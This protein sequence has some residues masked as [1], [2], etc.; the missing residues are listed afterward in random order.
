MR[1]KDL[2]LIKKFTKRQLLDQ[3]GFTADETQTILDYQK[4]LPILVED[5]GNIEHFCVNAS[6]LH[7]QLKVKARL[8]RWAENNIISI[9]E[10]N[11]DY[12]IMFKD[13]ENN[14][15]AFEDHCSLSPQ[16]LNAIG[17]S[18]V[19]MLTLDVSKEIAMFA[20]TALHA[21]AELK[22][23]SRLAR[24]YFILMEK[25]VKSN[26]EWELIRYPLRQGYK[27]MQKALDEYMVRMVQRNAD[28]WD[29]R[30]EA[31]AINIIATGF[32][33]KEIRSYVGCKDNITRDSLTATYN[34][35][36]LKLQEWNILFLGMNMN[37]YERYSKLKESFDIFFPN[38]VSI[39]EDVDINK[40][41]GNKQKLLD[42]AKSKLM[43]T[44]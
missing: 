13:S 43:K 10:E 24:R 6:D 34:E 28:D 27:Q 32:P 33:A 2:I 16:K 31:D 40:I 12:E 35:Y 9:F 1:R 3:C 37:R 36:L 11:K 5:N 23:L 19:Y 41:K 22:E 26:M 44:A 7:S 8:S 4:K 20:G 38:A 30:F 18:K 15:V 42:E 14:T 39:K 21:N 25:A 29:Y 17:V